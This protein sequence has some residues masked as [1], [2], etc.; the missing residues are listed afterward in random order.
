LD[1]FTTL[2]ILLSRWYVV[3]PS[4]L[5]TLAAAFAASAA[6][7]PS[8]KATSTLVLLGPATARQD[9]SGN[10]TRVQ[11]N[12]YLD[13]G[14]TLEVTADIL[15][16]IM[17]SPA[18]AE[19]LAARGLTADYE[20]GAEPDPGG[21][22]TPILTI[23][24]IGPDPE[25][26]KATAQGVAAQIRSE[27]QRRQTAAGAPKADFIRVDQVTTPTSAERQLGSKFRAAAAAG[28]LGLALTFG[29]AFLAESISE[30]RAARRRRPAWGVPD[31]PTG[32]EGPAPPRVPAPPA[33]AVLPH[34]KPPAAT[35][36]AR[37]PEE[38]GV[39]RLATRRVD[40]VTATRHNHAAAG[41]NGQRATMAGQHPAAPEEASPRHLKQDDRTEPMPGEWQAEQVDVWAAP[42]P[43][44]KA[45][46]DRDGGAGAWPVGPGG[47]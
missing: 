42:N 13:F 11:T 34:G 24:A 18:T 23:V 19:Q 44:G 29:L 20:V 33:A 7:A 47:R 27:L 31:A 9:A 36:P 38:S 21:R 10:A 15:S 12:A 5:F 25:I 39:A 22:D 3:V 37:P 28:A 4:M 14:G 30:R 40:V 45:D 2:R 26:A 35:G 32:A 46:Q 41:G 1:F 6:V 43:G 17:M 16:R 8:W